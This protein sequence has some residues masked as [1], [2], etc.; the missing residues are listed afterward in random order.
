H[1]H[2]PAINILT[3]RR[4]LGSHIHTLIRQANTLKLASSEPAFYTDIP[5]HLA[6]LVSP[7]HHLSG[8]EVYYE[9][10]IN[11]PYLD[12]TAML[13]E[14]LGVLSGVKTLSVR[15]PGGRPSFAGI[16]A[17]EIQS[18]FNRISSPSNPL[19]NLRY[20][21]LSLQLPLQLAL[22]P[23]DLALSV[24]RRLPNLQLVAIA[25]PKKAGSADRSIWGLGGPGGHPPG[26][27]M[28]G[29]ELKVWEVRREGGG[30]E[31]GEQV[32]SVVEVAPSMGRKYGFYLLPRHLARLQSAAKEL[33][34]EPNI[35]LDTAEF[36]RELQKSVGLLGNNVRQRVRVVMTRDLRYNVTSTS[37][38]KI[39]SRAFSLRLDTTATD[40]PPRAT[41]KSTDREMYESARARVG[42]DYASNGG[43]HDPPFDVLMWNTRGDVTET[44]IANFAVYLEGPELIAAVSGWNGSKERGAYVTP[45]ADRGLIAGVMRAELLDNGEL[46]EGNITREDVLRYARY[47]DSYPMVCFN[48]VRGMYSVR[49][50]A[51]IADDLASPSDEACSRLIDTMP[52]KNQ[53]LAPIPLP[54]LFLDIPTSRTAS[55]TPDTTPCLTPVSSARRSSASS[56]QR[57]PKRN[58]ESPDLSS[59]PLQPE[60]SLP[61]VWRRG[62]IIDCYDSYTNNLLQL[63]DQEDSLP[64]GSFSASLAS[65]VTVLRADQLS[66]PDFEANVLPHLDFVILSPGPGSPHVP[67]DIGVGGNLLLAMASERLSFRP[68]PVLGVCLGY[69]ALAALFGGKVIP[70]GELVHG[71]TVPVQHDGS[72]LFEGL[73]AGQPLRMVRYNSL[74][75]DASALPAELEV[76]A[77][78]PNDKEIM[79]LKHKSLPLYG[80]QFHP[81]SIC[82]RR[83]MQGVDPGKQILRN[84]MNIV[85]N[86]W[87]AHGRTDRLPLP[88]DI[89]QLGVLDLAESNRII[90]P[91][92]RHPSPRSLPDAVPLEVVRQDIGSFIPSFARA[93]P[94]LIFEATSYSPDVPFFWLDSA[95]AAPGDTFAR[96]SYMGP[97]ALDQCISY[98]LATHV[99]SCGSGKRT[100]LPEGDTFW[101]WMDRVQSDLAKRV[102]AGKGS[103]G[104]RCGFVGYFGYEMKTGALP[105][106]T[107]LPKNDNSTAQTPDGQFMFADRLLAYDHWSNSWSV[108]G[109]VRRTNDASSETL[110]CRDIGIQVGMSASEFSSWVDSVKQSINTL[111]AA[112]TSTNIDPLPLRFSFNSTPDAYKTAIKACQSHIADGNSY[113]ICLTG[114][115]TASSSDSPLDY[116]SVYKHFRTQNPASHAAFV[117]FPATQTTIM[118][119]SPELFIRFDGENGRQAVMKPIKG[120]LK[121]RSMTGAPKLRSV[122]LLD[123]LETSSWRGIYSGCLGFLSLDD[124]AVFSVVIRTL[125][126]CGDRLSYGAG[127]AITWL[128]DVDEEWAEV[129]LKA[130]SVLKG[131][132]ARAD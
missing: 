42:A 47:P 95:A 91:F 16:E 69:Q 122:Q 76:I 129:V 82:S 88:S 22:I 64:T 114:Q 66:W 54:N 50:D 119:C 96:F 77:I 130:Q 94:D 72:G 75:V 32:V 117:T 93:R 116:L 103:E 40:P 110:L 111:Q 33:F 9:D 100:T 68:I 6:G 74:M 84:F 78:D 126:A 45:R 63:F 7:A 15:L 26:W 39:P 19:S 21:F 37:L 79:G 71:R 86:F 113:E 80:V 58:L 13:A 51:P 81:E 105:G 35:T 41:H 89:R 36:R 34:S 109:L 104:L 121:R 97:A 14:F 120:T 10:G 85:D 99:I 112:T 23:A 20:L 123:S 8:I 70:A 57:I 55:T 108:L 5:R 101:H 27:G 53:D 18:L 43:P 12:P 30:E 131:R 125:V 65:Y 28:S 1:V 73:P 124:R 106:Y 102:D 60:F 38:P 52:S 11:L 2:F 92:V 59:A 98:D 62:V 128:S 4:P 132:V 29:G 48:A 25:A 107:A 67:R 24:A 83:S 3:C 115:Y 118:S 87:V 17:P 46:V 44:S 61:F 49:L 31:E 56:L 127:G 90:S